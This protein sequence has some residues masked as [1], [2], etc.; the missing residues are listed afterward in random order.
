MPVQWP[1]LLP[2]DFDVVVAALPPRVRQHGVSFAPP[3][4]RSAVDK[5]RVA[6]KLAETLKGLKRVTEARWGRRVK[7]DAELRSEARDYLAQLEKDAPN[8]P[9]IVV[10]DEFRKSL[11]LPA[12]SGS[13]I[14]G[15]F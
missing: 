8:Q 3:S 12:G 10:S 14:P 11:G 9:P 13:K 2:V 15:D 4:P 7:T 6:A 1:G 5:A